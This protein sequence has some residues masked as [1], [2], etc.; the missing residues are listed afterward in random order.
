LI[1]RQDTARLAGLAGPILDESHRRDD[2]SKVR[3]RA[4]RRDGVVA[5]DVDE[6]GV[7]LV[8]RA[9]RQVPPGSSL[10]R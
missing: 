6:A 8:E 3:V 7:A 1:D 2:A 10:H 4:Q 5:V 9:R